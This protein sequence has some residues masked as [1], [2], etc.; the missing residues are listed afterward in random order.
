[1]LAGKGVIQ[2]GERQGKIR[3]DIGAL[4]RRGGF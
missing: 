2:A 1:M 3:T 4:S